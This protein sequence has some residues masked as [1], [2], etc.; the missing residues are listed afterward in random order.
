MW[1]PQT[2]FVTVEGHTSQQK[3]L[4]SDMQQVLNYI[5][6]NVCYNTQHLLYKS[7]C[8]TSQTT[9]H[10]CQ[11]VLYIKYITQQQ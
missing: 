7:H 8:N 4:P 5:T 1:Q 10:Q 11:Y 9:L 3:T 6:V 2:V